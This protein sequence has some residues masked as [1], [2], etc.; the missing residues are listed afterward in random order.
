[1]SRKGILL[2]AALG[3][4]LALA[5]CQSARLGG[6]TAQVA[7]A[8]ANP[9]AG[10]WRSAD[11][12]AVSTFEGGAFQSRLADTGELVANGRYSPVG[13]SQYRVEWYSVRAKANTAATCSLAGPAMLSCAQDGGSSFQLVRASA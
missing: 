11:G 7:A 1:M 8:P 9:L 5:A 3:L 10:T 6:G 2:L 4:P 13:P 12:I